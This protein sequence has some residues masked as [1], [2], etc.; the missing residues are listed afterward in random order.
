M[1][2]YFR[3]PVS[4][5]LKAVCSSS[6]IK[7][8]PC[9][10]SKAVFAGHRAAP[11]ATVYHGSLAVVLSLYVPNAESLTGYEVATGTGMQWR[12]GTPQK[13][14]DVQKDHFAK[15]LVYVGTHVCSQKCHT[16]HYACISS[17]S[18]VGNR[19]CKLTASWCHASAGMTPGICM[20]TV[21]ATCAK[22]SHRGKMLTM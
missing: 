13:C 1:L 5:C 7:V 15:Q 8:P 10:V 6:K 20:H 3:M 4:S 12:R 11:A 17:A 16:A 19:Q 14:K 2:V 9:C 21:G 22:N 18:F